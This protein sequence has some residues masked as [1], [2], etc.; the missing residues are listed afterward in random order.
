MGVAWYFRK[1]NNYKCKHRTKSQKL[2]AD[3][4]GPRK[5]PE[6]PEK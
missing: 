1:C 4:K 6:V 2:S 5:P 3:V